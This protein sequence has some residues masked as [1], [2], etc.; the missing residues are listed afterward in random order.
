MDQLLCEVAVETV[1]VMSDAQR[2]TER[3]AIP[4]AR[5]RS[6]FQYPVLK[7]GWPQQV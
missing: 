1:K 7:A 3:F 2:A 4:K 5:A 6:S